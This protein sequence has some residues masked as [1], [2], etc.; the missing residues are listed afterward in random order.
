M[1]KIIVT[2]FAA[3]FS[4]CMGTLSY[5]ATADSPAD[6][7]A[8]NYEV[9][10]SFSPATGPGDYDSGFGGNLG[11]GVMLKDV[12][13]NLEARLD[14]YFYQFKND[15]SW[16][17]GTYTR[18]PLTISAR[19]YVPFADKLRAFGQVG[20]ETSIDTH[21]TSDNK[22]INELNFGIAP[23]VGAE[24]FVSPKLSIFALALG[25]LIADNYF[26]MQFGIGIPF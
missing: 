6:Q 20:L 9:N 19:Y 22:K 8:N 17:T 5:A 16:G 26:S 7:T 13:M 24:F 11:A 3:M 2:L 1:K 23:G 18:V 14:I 21:D 10:V 15:F 12:D 4:L 25:H